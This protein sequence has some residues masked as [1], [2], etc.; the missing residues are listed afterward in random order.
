VTVNGMS[1][2]VFSYSFCRDEPINKDIIEI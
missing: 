1:I 2:F